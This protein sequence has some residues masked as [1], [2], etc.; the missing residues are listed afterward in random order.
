[1]D[2]HSSQVTLASIGLSAVWRFFITPKRKEIIN[3]MM[4][5]VTDAVIS[6]GYGGAPAFHS[7]EDGR[8]LSFKI[9]CKVYDKRADKETRWVNFNV[10]AFDDLA[11]RVRRMNLKEGSHINVMGNFDMKPWVNRE[12]GEIT[13]WPTIRAVNIEYAA[14]ALPKQDAQTAQKAVP[15]QDKQEQS[16]LPPEQL[17]GFTGYEP[18]GGGNSYYPDET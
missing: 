18:F 7:S 10:N 9:G 13:T 15:V 2:S 12:T 3:M 6:K 16:A 5:L 17:P 4:Q 1:M 8:M 14:S 11:E